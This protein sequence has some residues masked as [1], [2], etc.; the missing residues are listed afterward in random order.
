MSKVLGPK[1]QHLRSIPSRSAVH[2]FCIEC[3][4]WNVQNIFKVYGSRPKVIIIIVPIMI[5][6]HIWSSMGKLARFM[7]QV[8]LMV[9]R[10]LRSTYD[11]HH[12]D[13]DENTMMMRTQ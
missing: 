8:A 7:G 4:K 2:L 1:V 11:D 12:H 3:K 6:V 13:E 5:T 9:R 10:M